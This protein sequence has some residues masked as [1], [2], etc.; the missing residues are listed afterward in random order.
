MWIKWT[1]HIRGSQEARAV[2]LGC[3]ARIYRLQPEYINAGAGGMA[4][5]WHGG[6]GEGLDDAGGEERGGA[7]VHVQRCRPARLAVTGDEW[8]TLGCAPGP[9]TAGGGAAGRGRTGGQRAQLLVR[10]LD[11]VIPSIPRLKIHFLK[12]TL[13]NTCNFPMTSSC[14]LR[15]LFE[16]SPTPNDTVQAWITAQ[17]HID[18]RLSSTTSRYLNPVRRY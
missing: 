16:G 1:T 4:R 17:N 7:V 2:P 8:S 6:V 10:T 9:V 13:Q 3:P 15:W 5:D 12:A 11:S 18:N 14:D